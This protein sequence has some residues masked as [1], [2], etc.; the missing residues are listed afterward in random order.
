MSDTS[1]GN[2]GWF[3]LQERWL[4]LDFGNFRQR[5][6]WLSPKVTTTDIVRYLAVRS[7]NRVPQLWEH[8][9]QWL[10]DTVVTQIY[11]CDA[12]S[13]LEYLATGLG[14][15]ADQRGRDRIHSVQT[16]S[17]FR[18]RGE[19][20]EVV[21]QVGPPLAKARPMVRVMGEIS[22]SSSAAPVAAVSAHNAASGAASSSAT[23]TSIGSW[24]S[25]KTR[26]QC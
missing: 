14:V 11:E 25:S 3:P 20:G 10:T 1:P 6:S 21:V 24:R 23:G 17:R 2:V 18:L 26:P 19:D 7:W 8:C 5:G 22:T 13:C 9:V 16:L 12:R 15:M 4:P